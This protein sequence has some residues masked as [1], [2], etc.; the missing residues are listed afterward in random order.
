MNVDDRLAILERIGEYSQAW[1]GRDSERYAR[2][3]T[4][5]GVFEIFT[6][7]S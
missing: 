5:D 6:L 4:E 2:L 7:A 3:F 1:D